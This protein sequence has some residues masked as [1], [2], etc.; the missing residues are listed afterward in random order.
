[1]PGFQS[2]TDEPFAWV[3]SIPYESIAGQVPKASLGEPNASVLPFF[4]TRIVAWPFWTRAFSPVNKGMTFAYINYQDKTAN[5]TDPVPATVSLDQEGAKY[6]GVLHV[7]Q[8]GKYDVSWNLDGRTI[9]R[10]DDKKVI[11]VW[12]FTTT[13]VMDPPS[14]G[15]KSVFLK[16]GDHP[17][18]VDTCFQR[19]QKAPEITLH[20]RGTPGD[21]QSLWSGFN[22]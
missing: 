7:A 16:A 19:S 17:V 3:C 12:F 13:N 21:G 10:V 2:P 1:M 20:R 11:D 5:A 15:K 8:D 9:F 22:L 14:K 6:Q 18:E 4:E